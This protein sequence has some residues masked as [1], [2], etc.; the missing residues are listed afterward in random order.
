MK[1]IIEESGLIARLWD[2]GDG[3]L[4][5]TTELQANLNLP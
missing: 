3:N 2:D 4:S 5:K 1:R